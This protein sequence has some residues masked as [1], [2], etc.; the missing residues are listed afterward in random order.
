LVLLAGPASQ[1]SVKG[2]LR[3]LDWAGQGSLFSPNT[4]VAIWQHAGKNE[5]LPEADFMLEGLVAT[6]FDFA[7]LST[8]DPATSRLQRWLAPQKTDEP[9]GIG[10]GLPALPNIIYP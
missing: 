9:P 8:A 6:A 5:T 10:A 3:S 7:G 2:L 4:A 1:K